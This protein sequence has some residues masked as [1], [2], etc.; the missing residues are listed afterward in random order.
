MWA[1]YSHIPAQRFAALPRDKNDAILL[2]FFILIITDSI[3]MPL[4]LLLLFS[5]SFSV[6][7]C[8]WFKLFKVVSGKRCSLL[9]TALTPGARYDQVISAFGGKGYLAET[10]QQVREAFLSCL[11]DSQT[12]SLINIIVSSTAGKKPQVDCDIVCL[13]MQF[14]SYL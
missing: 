8:L 4:L 3:A 1:C 14:T 12:T 7:F 5:I 13:H 6:F 10:R 2:L 11:A 9:P